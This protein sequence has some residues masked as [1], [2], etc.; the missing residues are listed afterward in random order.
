[1]S[2]W[3]FFGLGKGLRRKVGTQQ[4]AGSSDYSDT[5]APVD[6]D[7]AMQVSAFWACAR[8]LTET[9]A[10][11]PIVPYK[12]DS[13]GIKTK[14]YDNEV[15][16]LLNYMPNK[17]QTKVEFF[18]TLMLQ[19]VT[20]GNCY[21]AI[22]RGVQ[23]NIVSLIP[24]MSA[25]MIVTLTDD[26]EI[27]YEYN[28]ADNDTVFYSSKSIWHVKIFG[29][30]IVG[31]SPMSHSAKALGTAIALEE[32]VS[33]LAKNGGNPSGLLMID[34]MLKPEQ[35]ISI[36]QQLNKKA[37]SGGSLFVLEAGMTYQQTSINPTDQ[38]LLQNRRFQIE[39]IARFMGVPS[40][41]INDTSAT[42]T[43]GS[44]IGQ[45]NEGFYK[46]NLKPYLE[47]FESSMVRFL[48]SPEDVGKKEI[49][50]NFDSLLR[51]DR[52]TRAEAAS[53]EINSGQSTPNEIRVS[54]GKPP[55]EGGD[56]IFINGALQTAEQLAQG[57]NDGA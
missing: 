10:S 20:D 16:R 15:W 51:A 24:L 50:F 44:G 6:F 26:G 45:I 29:N 37:S 47:R 40:V 11:M 3:S 5:A 7:S 12:Y 13:E 55:K 32:R 52:K 38:Q 17:Y 42:T 34:K 28:T 48:M 39:D 30:G 43:W 21:C 35:R 57:D 49:E 46:L 56:N 53:T 1:M 41:L 54:E 31:L 8:L 4:S 25:Q 23:G 27:M 2:I 14:D 9:V 22:E 18:E 33:V 36:E 19:L